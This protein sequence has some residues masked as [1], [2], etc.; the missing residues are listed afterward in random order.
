MFHFAI[1]VK[2]FCLA[3]SLLLNSVAIHYVAKKR[4]WLL[5]ITYSHQHFWK[6]L[7]SKALKFANMVKLDYEDMIHQRKETENFF[8]NAMNT[9]LLLQIFFPIS[10]TC[11]NY[12]PYEW[13]QIP[14][15]KPNI[16]R[17]S[18]WASLVP[19]AGKV[20]QVLLARRLKDSKK[21]SNCWNWHLTDR[22]KI[23][24]MSRKEALHRFQARCLG[25]HCTRWR[26]RWW[27]D[28]GNR[29]S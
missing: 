5:A 10:I 15:F 17:K 7:E 28:E 24:K 26:W 2:N 21:L 23:P 6:Q 14:S 11:K 16:H 18:W 19:Q 25:G 3:L 13:V 29:P 12:L 9:P 27:S 20:S 4:V 1:L 22:A 8:W